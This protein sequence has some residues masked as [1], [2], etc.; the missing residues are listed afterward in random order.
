MLRSLVGSE[1]C[2]RDSCMYVLPREF[3][4]FY[5]ADHSPTHMHLQEKPSSGEGRMI[6]F[7]LEGIRPLIGDAGSLMAWSGCAVHWG[8]AC[9]KAAAVRARASMAFV[10]R[11]GDAVHDDENPPLTKQQVDS[12]DARQRLDLVVLQRQSSDK[13]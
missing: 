13:L 2:I 5:D 6:W 12:L 1:M 9:Q 10:F 8:S 4:G 7:P 11:R 3:D